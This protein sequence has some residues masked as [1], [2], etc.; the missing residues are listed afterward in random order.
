MGGTNVDAVIIENGRIV[1]S[2]KHVIDQHNIFQSIWTTLQDILKNVDT[3]KI[4]QM[5][6]STTVST[7]AIVENNISKVALFIQSGPGLKTDFLTSGN[8]NIFLSGSI[9]HR[10]RVVKEFNKNEVTNQMNQLKDQDI[11]NCGVITK[12]ST[13]NPN[14]ELKISQ[15]LE[16]N[17]SH[18]TLEHT[19]SVKLN[20]PRRLNTTYLNAAVYDTF[21]SFSKQIKIAMEKEGLQHIPINVLKADG[22]TMNLSGAENLPVETIL[23]GPAAS[24]MGMNALLSSNKDTI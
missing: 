24:F 9:D 22:G 21:K 13:R 15:L 2:V 12:F 14:P 19:I 20:V 4:K 10:G 3:S 7:N 5:N 1:N 23:S 11:K 16:K 6:L 18:I 17:F 8:E